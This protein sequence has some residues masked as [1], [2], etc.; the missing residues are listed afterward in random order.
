[1]VRGERDAAGRRAEGARCPAAPKTC[2]TSGRA[3]ATAPNCCERRGGI[4]SRPRPVLD[5]AA[6]QPEAGTKITHARGQAEPDQPIHCLLFRPHIRHHHT[7]AYWLMLRVRDAILN[8]LCATA[9]LTSLRRLGPCIA[10][11]SREDRGPHRLSRRAPKLNWPAGP[12]AA[13]AREFMTLGQNPIPH[14]AF[15]TNFRD[16]ISVAP[17]SHAVETRRA[18][19]RAS[20]LLGLAA[21][22]G[23]A[24]RNGECRRV[25]PA[26]D[27]RRISGLG[28]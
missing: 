3:S 6:D 11:I 15:Q 1:M 25:S 21:L 9:E 2:A 23:P 14:Y 12:R 24:A 16:E 18:E 10:A 20:A 4:G 19:R 27:R 17:Q 22:Q 26:G 5:T 7:A 28:N 8:L 13:K